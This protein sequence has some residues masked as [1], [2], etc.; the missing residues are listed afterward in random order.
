MWKFY[1]S[2]SSAKLLSK[3]I[4]TALRGRSISLEIWPLSF[5]EYLTAI[6][7]RL[8]KAPFSARIFDQLMAIFE[9][10]I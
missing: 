4:H 9:A 7:Y 6:Q 5:V 1:L 2:G 3:D 10:V 8:P